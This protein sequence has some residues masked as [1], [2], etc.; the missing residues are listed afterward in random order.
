V[1]TIYG[2]DAAFPDVAPSWDKKLI[3]TSETGN[4]S[5]PIGAILV[6][7]PTHR[8]AMRLD[9]LE[10]KEG[11]KQL[12]AHAYT[13]RLPDPVMAGKLFSMTTQLADRVAMYSFSPPAIEDCGELG[14]FLEDS[15]EA[16]LQ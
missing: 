8:G 6:I 7:D 4:V 9:R 15:L 11:W 3:R 2:P 1:Y 5:H 13:A 10:R 12:M 16:H 14:A